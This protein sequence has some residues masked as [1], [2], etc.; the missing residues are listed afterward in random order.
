MI[1][2]NIKSEINCNGR[3]LDL[4]CPKVMGILNITPDS[5][6]DGGEYLSE[7][8][9]EKRVE[10]IVSQ[11]ADIIDVGAYSSRPGASDVSEDEER[12]RLA[13]ALKIIREKYSEAIISVDTFRASIARFAVSEFGVDI[14]NDIS[15]GLFDDDM[16]PTI[17]D[18]QVPYIMMHIQ[19]TPAS[20]QKSPHYDDVTLEIIKFFSERIREANLLGIN[21]II[22]DPGFGFGKL[23]EHNY[24]LMSKLDYLSVLN[25]PMLVGISRKSMIYKPLSLTPSDVLAGTISLNTVALIKGASIIRVHDVAE[26][27]QT[28]EVFKRLS[29]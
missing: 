11:G 23:V 27:V 14:I 24:E 5:F 22:I 28:V 16:L 18:L 20:M 8:A 7:D 17:R 25:Y 1:N 3:L 29:V 15:S 13:I 21:D 12:A 19:G 10:K 6:Y 26:A 4:S 9:I 2:K